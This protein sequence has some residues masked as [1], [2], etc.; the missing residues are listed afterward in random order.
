MAEKYIVDGGFGA[1]FNDAKQG[2]SNANSDKDKDGSNDVDS[3][4]E[5]W[6]EENDYRN[7]GFGRDTG[8]AR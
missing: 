4:L 1:S 8:Q 2:Y 7:I 6:K 3:W 5:E